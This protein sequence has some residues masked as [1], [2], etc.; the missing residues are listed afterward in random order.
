MTL[1]S[2]IQGP[3]SGADGG[4][5]LG[6]VGIG[7]SCGASLSGKFS[8]KLDNIQQQLIKARKVNEKHCSTSNKTQSLVN[9][10]RE[11]V[12]SDDARRTFDFIVPMLK[13]MGAMSVDIPRLA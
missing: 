8:A 11:S 10:V 7:G 13:A 3:T 1:K 9:G 5:P 4:K 6:N 2:L 12:V